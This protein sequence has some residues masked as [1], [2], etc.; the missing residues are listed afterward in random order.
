MSVQ[1]DYERLLL[2]MNLGGH[3]RDGEAPEASIERW[4]HDSVA[5]ADVRQRLR[6]LLDQWETQINT[7]E[8]LIATECLEQ[9]DAALLTDQRT[10]TK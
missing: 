1:S 3:R 10:R 5:L 6:E 7:G 4:Q 8:W 2:F 9:L